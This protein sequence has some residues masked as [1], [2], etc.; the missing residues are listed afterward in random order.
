MTRAFNR[1]LRKA[2]GGR[3]VDDRWALLRAYLTANVRR[4]R[5]DLDEPAVGKLVTEHFESYQKDPPAVTDALRE[6]LLAFREGQRAKGRK[7]KARKAAEA[8]WKNTLKNVPAKGENAISATEHVSDT[9]NLHPSIP[10]EGM[11]DTKSA[12]EHR[13]ENQNCA[14]A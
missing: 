13:F 10:A 3:S 9:T 1:F 5:P 12:P 8:R 4:E 6:R 7:S 2:I 11:A 14:R